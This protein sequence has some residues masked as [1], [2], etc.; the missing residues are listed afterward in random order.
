MAE[1]QNVGKALPSQDD[2][3]QN[4]EADDLLEEC[5]VRSH[6]LKDEAMRVMSLRRLGNFSG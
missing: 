5:E 4:N 1:L 2:F 3:N 6:E